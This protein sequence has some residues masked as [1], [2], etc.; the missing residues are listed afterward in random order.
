MN[1]LRPLKVC[2]GVG[3]PPSPSPTHE[4]QDGEEGGK[5]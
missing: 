4:G 1:G 2:D 3:L 5:P